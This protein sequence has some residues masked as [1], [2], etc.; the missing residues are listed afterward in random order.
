MSFTFVDVLFNHQME[1][2]FLRLRRDK[3]KA[4]VATEDSSGDGKY[5]SSFLEQTDQTANCLSRK[6]LTSSKK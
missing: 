1:Y 2:V 3:I 6:L 5:G 4:A